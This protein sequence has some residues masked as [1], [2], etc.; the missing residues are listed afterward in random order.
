MTAKTSFQSFTENIFE[1]GSER[2]N[3]TDAGRARGHAL[4]SVLLKLDEIEVITT[5][6]SLGGPGHGRGR[7]GENRQ[8]GRQR[9][10]LL[11]AGKQY[12]NPQFVEGQLNGRH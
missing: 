12:I 9:K 10:R 7:T 11:R 3:M 6:C 5:I 8:A 2:I 1:F 4:L